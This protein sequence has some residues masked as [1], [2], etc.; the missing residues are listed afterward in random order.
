[1][2]KLNENIEL[3]LLEAIWLMRWNKDRTSLTAVLTEKE[4]T[5][6]CLDIVEE[7]NYAGYEIVRKYKNKKT[8]IKHE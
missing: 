8:K 5:Q 1:M 4:A 2:K 3:A 6:M 7:L